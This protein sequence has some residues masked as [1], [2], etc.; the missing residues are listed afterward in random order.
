MAL[1]GLRKY[2][3]KE[4]GLAFFKVSYLHIVYTVTSFISHIQIFPFLVISPTPSDVP[5]SFLTSPPLCVCVWYCG[6]YLQDHCLLTSNYTTEECVSSP[7][8]PLLPI[9]PQK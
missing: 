2:L 8:L 4:G 6:Y 9:G 5:L 3:C 1:E 7:W